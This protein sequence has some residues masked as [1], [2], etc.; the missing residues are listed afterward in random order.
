MLLNGVSVIVCTH[1]GVPRLEKTL[2]HIVRQQCTC[3]WELIVV[4]NASS[5]STLGY[6]TNYLSSHKHKFQWKVVREEQQGLIYA[7]LRGLKESNYAI[8]LFCD[9]DNAVTADYL[10]LGF[11]IFKINPLIGIVGGKGI[12]VFE[13][14][15][16]EWF[17]QYGHSFAVGPQAESTG[18]IKTKPAEL[19]GACTFFRKDLLKFYFDKNFKTVMRGRTGTS[20]VSGDDIEWCFLVQLQGYEVWYDDR[21][22]FEHWMP[23]KR[24]NWAYYLQLKKNISSG[25]GCLF[26]YVCLLKNPNL[27]LKQYLFLLLKKMFFSLFLFCKHRLKKSSGLFDETAEHELALISLQAKMLSY[28]KNSI[29][30]VLFFRYLQKWI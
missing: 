30:S 8:V 6:C 25:A 9:D 20:L 12:P 1:N 23:D 10:Q 15:R 27:S 22:Q 29:S 3:A 4:D 19:Y 16:P 17:N 11:D 7:R 21:L 14:E 5:D 24:M 2:A 26:P 28:W 18:V 13:S